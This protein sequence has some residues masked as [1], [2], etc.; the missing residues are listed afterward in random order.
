GQSRMLYGYTQQSQRA[1]HRMYDQWLPLG[2]VGII[3]AYNFPANVWAQNGFL[4]AIAGN[5]VIWKPS[6]K[7]P[8]TAIALQK[9][10]NQAA[11]E[12]GFEGVF[13][14]FIPDDNDV[15]ELMVQDKRVNMISFTGS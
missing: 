5:T 13:S 9:L 12:M 8:L 4:A 3:S 10:V 6:P 14:L 1:E 2:V 7:V 15:A 11:K